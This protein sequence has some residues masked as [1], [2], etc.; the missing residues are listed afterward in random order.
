MGHEQHPHDAGEPGGQRGDDDERV[1]PGLKVHDHEQVDEQ[2][3]EDQPEAE[4]DEGGVHAL[5]LAAHGDPVAGRQL[6][7]VLGHDL[8][9]LGGHA[10]EVAALHVG[11]DVE[12]GLHVGVADDR[13]HLA[14]LEGGQIAEQLRLA[15]RAGRDGRVHQRVDGVDAALGRLHGDD[16]V[17]AA[18]GIGPVVRAHDG[19][20]A[21][22]DEHAVGHVPLR[23]AELGGARAIDVDLQRRRVDHLVQVHVDGARNASHAGGDLQRDLVRRLLVVAGD[24]HVD[25]RRQPEVQDLA[26]DVRRL[27]EEGHAGKLP[28]QR[29]PQRLHPAGGRL[30][31]LRI[32][33]DEDLTVCCAEG[34]AV[35]EGEVD[36]LGL[37]DVVD[38]GGDLAVRN[39]PA[40]RRLD[41][42]E[43]LLGLLDT[44]ARRRPHVQPELARIHGGEEVAS[45]ERQQHQP[46]HDDDGEGAEH[47]CAPGQRELERP[48][49]GGAEPLELSLERVVDAREDAGRGRHLAVRLARE[50][51]AHQ[52]RD[53][54][55]REQVRREHREHDGHGQRREEILRRTGQEHHGHEDDA[56]RQRGDERRRGDLLGTVEDGLDEPGAEAE[57]AVDVLDLHGRVVDQ[58]ADGQREPA[59]RH[60]VERLAD[61][62]QDG[63]RGEDR[64][65]DR[66]DH[67]QRAAPAAEE[68]QD[69]HAGEQRGD[70]PLGQHAGDRGAHEE[71]LIEQLLDLHAGRGRRA[72]RGQELF[73]LLDDG[74]RRGAALLDD[75]EQRRAPA[76]LAD[77]VRL[78]REAVA[79]VPHVAHVHHGAVDVLHRQVI[80][81]GHRVRAAVEAD[82]VLARPELHAAGGQRQVLEIHG[83]ADV[84]RRDPLRQER[85][86][87]EVHHDLTRLAAVRQRQRD[88]LDRCDLL[89]DAVDAVVVELGL[90]DPLAAERELDDR[91]AGG[92]VLDDERRHGARRHPAKDRLRYG[93]HLRQ[94]RL[95]V[96]V[97][98]EVDLDDG[99]AGV[100]LRLDR[101]HVADR[102]GD[103]VLGERRDP[104]RHVFAGQTVVVPDHRD[105]R[106]LDLRKDVGRGGDDREHAEEQD[107]QS[108]DHEGVGAPEGETND[109]HEPGS[110]PCTVD[111]PG[112]RRDSRQDARP[113]T[114]ARRGH[115]ASAG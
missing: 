62:A 4:P 115:G 9:H 63:Q 71:R 40:D 13:G 60:H 59:Q 27:E 108:H 86:R 26:D 43:D 101:P 45:D 42:G 107:G 31:T 36:R 25:R 76:V 21:E 6:R 89:A 97:G 78:H 105:D 30:V 100:R 29:F 48:H 83:V 47:A 68:Q 87:V 19:A 75:G 41:G 11:V 57:V 12:D 64:E 16:I 17:D 109:P 10:A 73:Q 37:A 104:R 114:W 54:R 106:D 77:D 18:A 102:G 98:L 113:W 56:D 51:I 7:A 23:E 33:R 65:G 8:L 2:D 67:H 80:E 28:R 93:G 38:H 90:R 53:D 72:D 103:R 5:H 32:Q 35:R 46:A 34:H 52:R 81:G 112:P 85:L 99:H 69:H 15:G 66:G 22:R 55:A 44:G 94:R 70:R 24:L 20:R 49:V 111:A 95:H 3:G 61:C 110:C 74:E 1:E 14:P 50:Q 88:A 91:H 84:G 58:D 39:D 79:H 92:V 82:A 96:H